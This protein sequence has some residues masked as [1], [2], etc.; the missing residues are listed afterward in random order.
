[1]SDEL[2]NLEDDGPEIP[3]ADAAPVE[4]AAAPEP[5]APTPEE[6]DDPTKVD[7]RDIPKVSGLLAALKSERESNKALKARAEQ[8]AQLE[9]EVADLRPY[10]KFLKDN[11]QL[12]QPRQPEPAPVADQPSIDPEAEELARLLDLYTPEGQPDIKRAS[13]FLTVADKRADKRVQQAV[14][15]VHELARHIAI[16]RQDG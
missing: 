16:S 11:P 14:A 2:I 8:A 6:I 15:P 9:A 12:L 3:A 4:V 7:L 1:M 10:A 13:K 5:A